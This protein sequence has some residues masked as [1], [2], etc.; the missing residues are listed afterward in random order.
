MG[1]NHSLNRGLRWSFGGY[2]ILT[3]PNT[4][5][6]PDY[7]NGVTP[8]G[9]DV[10]AH[11]SLPDSSLLFAGE[12]AGHEFLIPSPVALRPAANHRW[13]SMHR[14][15]A[16]VV[17]LGGT[18]D[19]EYPDSQPLGPRAGNVDWTDGK[20]RLS[21]WGPN[22]RYWYQTAP[23]GRFETQHVLDLY[24]GLI[25]YAN[26]M[27]A[28]IYFRPE[29]TNRIGY[30]YRFDAHIDEVCYHAKPGIEMSYALEDHYRSL[31]V[32]VNGF[33]FGPYSREIYSKGLIVATAPA[34]VLGCA[35][36]RHPVT[37]ERMLIAICNHSGTYQNSANY[38]RAY[39]LEND[40]WRELASLAHAL[41][42]ASF[43]PYIYTDSVFEFV[44]NGGS[45]TQS[46]QVKDEFIARSM[47][48]QAIWCFNQSGNE[49]VSIRF[50][51][52][53]EKKVLFQLS[54]NNGELSGNFNYA[55]TA[56]SITTTVSQEF[57][58]DYIGAG[59]IDFDE[60]TDNSQSGSASIGK[61]GRRYLAFDY[62]DDAMVSLYI[63]VNNAISFSGNNSVSFANPETDLV[64]S[65][66]MS[67]ISTNSAS[68]ALVLNG[69]VID[70]LSASFSEGL[71]FVSEYRSSGTV[72]SAQCGRT[73]TN[74]HAE[75]IVIQWA[76]LRYSAIGYVKSKI[77][78]LSAVSETSFDST[79]DQTRV[80]Y[81]SPG[82]VDIT[83]G[84]DIKSTVSSAGGS[85]ATIIVIDGQQVKNDSYEIVTSATN[86]S[87]FPLG[88]IPA[89]DW[90]D[91][92]HQDYT[93]YQKVQYICDGIRSN[94]SGAA[95]QSSFVPVSISS[96]C[97]NKGMCIEPD[98]VFL[99]M[100]YCSASFRSKESYIM[101]GLELGEAFRHYFNS[102]LKSHAITPTSWGKTLR[103]LSS[104]GASIDYN[105]GG[106]LGNIAPMTAGQ[107]EAVP[108]SLNVGLNY[109]NES[110]HEGFALAGMPT[111]TLIGVP[112]HRIE[113]TA[114][115][116]AASGLPSELFDGQTHFGPVRFI[117]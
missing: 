71:A 6:L 117:R 24:P 44:Y 84:V 109:A 81:T 42:N 95:V 21:W 49:A 57:G 85:T 30:D 54:M 89:F 68:E 93:E 82:G 113:Q 110:I 108:L 111:F 34:P 105:A 100:G 76:D 26:R 9:L 32:P 41:P 11:Q 59:I 67:E 94:M 75:S 87:D 78:G 43:D 112:D 115:L 7:R 25:C 22:S 51:G 47:S 8:F 86:Y 45:P 97:P 56:N 40:S 15:P 16:A 20:I 19:A 12:F 83:S 69:A 64:I 29:I 73:A 23:R 10:V 98:L 80:V 106:W 96:I 62:I 61:V 31:I 90:I 13:K 36:Y 2:L 116:V 101:H 58:P 52:T 107:A 35:Y 27:P 70:N 92:E 91:T 114:G 14:D 46:I 63:D 60:Y 48:I 103:W 37:K 4:G 1:G 50:D 88:Y 99:G 65:R 39:V 33:S 17:T 53:S 38:D 18:A 5:S 74:S 79:V 72:V 77:N 104:M 3:N 102:P 28:R 55:D 66:D